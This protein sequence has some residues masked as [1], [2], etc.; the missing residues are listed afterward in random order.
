M[1][2]LSKPTT[3]F[4]MDMPQGPPEVNTQASRAPGIWASA[5]TTWGL[6]VGACGLRFWARHLTRTGY[7]LD[8]WLALLA[9]VSQPYNPIE[10]LH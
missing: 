4:D 7:R 9:L 2:T 10:P 5:M 3:F 8:D 6:A 1:S